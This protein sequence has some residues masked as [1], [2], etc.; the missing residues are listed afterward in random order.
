ML[1]NWFYHFLNYWMRWTSHRYRK[2]KRKVV[3]RSLIHSC[4][5][6]V[7]AK[8][9]SKVKLTARR[10]KCS[11]E[12]LD[13][14]QLDFTGLVMGMS[15]NPKVSCHCW[16]NELEAEGYDII[17]GHL[18]VL[19]QWPPSKVVMCPYWVNDVM[20]IPTPLHTCGC[21]LVGLGVRLRVRT[22][23]SAVIAGPMIFRQKV[24]TLL[25]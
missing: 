15:L 1:T 6:S 21:V 9:W 2:N 19:G 20:S 22:R 25:I 11:G 23:K 14:K 7:T 12:Q 4:S 16:A 5:Q 13:L 18:V 8:Y 17:D 3:N 24:M 10:L